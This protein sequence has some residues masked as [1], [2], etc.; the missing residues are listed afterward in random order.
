M[1]SPRIYGV[2]GYYWGESVLHPREIVPNGARILQ[3]AVAKLFRVA[4]SREE[5]SQVTSQSDDLITLN[6]RHLKSTA[7]AIRSYKAQ[8]YKGD[9]TVMRTPQG[10]VMALGRRSLG[11]ATVTRGTIRVID[12][13]GAHLSMLD[14]PYIAS[15]TEKL[16]NWLSEK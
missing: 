7:A 10:R 2:L 14:E 8:E 6:E 16:I 11:W 4:R 12:V 1:D 15:V 3:E 9:I 13:S 5:R